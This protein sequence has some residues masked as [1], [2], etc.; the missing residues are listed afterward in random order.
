MPIVTRNV[1]P[2]RGVRT[3]PASWSRVERGPSAATACYAS[4]GSDT[5]P[6]DTVSFDESK[7]KPKDRYVLP[8][9]WD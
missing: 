7:L 8:D 9:E 6:R 4:V 1:R 5:S 3:R 2:T